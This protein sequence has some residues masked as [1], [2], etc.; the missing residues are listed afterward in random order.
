[1]K[2]TKE[3]INNTIINNLIKEVIEV[4]PEDGFVSDKEIRPTKIQNYGE[5]N[6]T[7]YHKGYAKTVS[8]TTN[9]PRV[10]RLFVKFMC[11]IF[12]ISGL[13]MLLLFR[14]LFFG[15]IFVGISIFI[16]IKENKEIDKIAK[17]L[18]NKGQD[19]TI[20]S[21]EEKEQLINEIITLFKQGFMESA[22]STFTKYNYKVFVKTT[23]PIY[24]I[25]VAI[26][27]TFISIFINIFLGLFLL[28]I[29]LLSGLLYY[30]LL[31]KIF[32]H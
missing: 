24:C 22:T 28:I 9:D 10:T 27:V 3:K 25:V 12:F 18:K 13:I 32:K 29:L 17:E 16:Y 5:E 11:R 20:D 7:T 19:V 15:I 30:Y 4:T 8:Y 23:I 21:I 14:D 1:M 26:V 6:I 31:K 2:K